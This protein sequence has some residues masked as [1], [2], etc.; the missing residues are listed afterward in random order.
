MIYLDNAATSFPKPECVARAMYEYMTENGAN[1]N[2]GVYSPARDAELKLLSLRERLCTLFGLDDPRRATITP[3]ATASLNMAIKGL[4][5]PGDHCIVGSMEHN[6]VMRPL[7]Q[8]GKTGVSFDRIHADTEGHIR[9]KDMLPLIRPNTR[10]AVVSHASNVCGTIADIEAIGELCKKRGIFLLLDASQT[11]GC[12]PID[13]KAMGLSA[14]AASGHKALMG[15][16]GIGI[17][18]MDKAFSDALEPLI[19]GGTGSMSDSE[20]IPPYLPDRFEAGTPNIP[21]I[22]GLESALSF[23]QT[24]TV[25]AV[26]KKEQSLTEMLIDGLTDIKD[27]RILGAADIRERTGVVSIDFLNTD[28]ADAARRLAE[29]GIMTRCGLHCAPSAH[30]ALGTMPSGTVRLS[31]GFYT[32]ERDIYSAVSAVRETAR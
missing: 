15:P 12:V 6:A 7:M 26:R 5:K 13:F 21:G 17:L 30:I 20:E 14:L 23:L 29:L 1:V 4:L 18:L 27:I 28:N 16:S 11:A 31:I 24:E 32:T 25:E 10:L 19:S 2:R 9:A 8:L 22:Y 3:G